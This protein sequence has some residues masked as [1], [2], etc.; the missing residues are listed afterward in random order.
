MT[1]KRPSPRSSRSEAARG[2]LSRHPPRRA[3]RSNPPACLIKMILIAKMEPNDSNGPFPFVISSLTASEAL[4]RARLKGLALRCRILV[5]GFLLAAVLFLPRDR[6]QRNFRFSV[7]QR[8][9]ASESS[10]VAMAFFYAPDKTLIQAGE[11]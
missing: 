2:S 4:R 9:S 8:S 3:S 5:T 7:V 10:S 1:R 6:L 11:L